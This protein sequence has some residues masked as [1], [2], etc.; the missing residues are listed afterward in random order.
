MEA[1][2]GSYVAFSASAGKTAS[3]GPEGKHG[4]FTEHLLEEIRQPLPVSEVFR[5]VRQEVFKASGGTQL[6]YMDDQMIADFHLAGSK[7]SEPSRA[8]PSANTPADRQMEE[9]KLLYQ[10][11]KCAD[12]I[13]ILEKLVKVDP[14]N[15][16]SKNALGLRMSGNA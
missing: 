3:D 4:L 2:L 16:F 8:E 6:P 10:S 15:P 11:K 12:A 5:K 1:G 9:A 7:T 13:A 14:L